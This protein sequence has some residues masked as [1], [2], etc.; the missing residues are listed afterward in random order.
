[1]SDR[2]H[3]AEMPRLDAFDEEFG[4]DPVAIQRGRRRRIVRRFWALAAVTL[5]AGVIAALALFWSTA[6]GRLRL[7]LQSAP[8]S[9]QSASREATHEE[10]DRLRR[11]MDTLRNEIG[12]LTRAQQ[13][14]ADTI[15]AL[16]AA[17]QEA[18]SHQPPLVYWYSNP[19][20][21]ELSIA[22]QPPPGVVLPPRRPTTARRESRGV[23][24]RERSASLP[25]RPAARSEA[26]RA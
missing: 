9:P 24:R 22:S 18:R 15:A 3:W 11:E 6:D 7:E 1:M 21:L 25:L 12:E 17:E 14:A 2:L 13:Q 23:R 5:G 4:Q 26:A 8:P 16:Q 19:A 20:T 10:L